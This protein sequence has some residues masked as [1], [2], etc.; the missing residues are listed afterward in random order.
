MKLEF[1]RQILEKE[2]IK[3]KIDGNPSSGNRV[4]VCVRKDWYSLFK[5]FLKHLKIRK[6]RWSVR[7][8]LVHV[9]VTWRC[10]HFIKVNQD[11]IRVFVAW[12]HCKINI[13]VDIV[14]IVYHLVIYMQSN[15]IHKV[16]IMTEFYSSRM[17]TRHIPDLT[18]PS[19][20]AFVYKL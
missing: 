1:W 6:Y 3:F 5:V 20:G 17:L 12:T 14:G 10:A 15:K 11:L 19:S 13:I 7:T 16:F 4:A 8:I 9:I 18:G 2:R